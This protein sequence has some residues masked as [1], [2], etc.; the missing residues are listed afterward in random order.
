ML[1]F[2][3]IL[4]RFCE[5][6]CVLY[7][8]FFS[9]SEAIWRVNSWSGLDFCVVIGMMLKCNELKVVYSFMNLF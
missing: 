2:N 6:V 3:I 7:L 1:C 8:V 4:V 5:N 9:V